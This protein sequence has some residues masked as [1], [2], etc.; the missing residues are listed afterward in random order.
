MRVRKEGHFNHELRHL[1]P[2]ALAL[3]YDIKEMPAAAILVMSGHKRNIWMELIK[4]K[5]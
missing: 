4:K 3:L 5:H 1:F 2:L